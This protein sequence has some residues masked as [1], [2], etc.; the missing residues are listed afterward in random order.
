MGWQHA[1]R[2]DGVRA[3]RAVAQRVGVPGV[4]DNA[5]RAKVQTMVAGILAATSE[6]RTRKKVAKLV[7]SYEAT[8]KSPGVSAPAP[9]AAPEPSVRF[10][11]KSMLLTYN[12]DFFGKAFPDGTAAADD[13][14][15]L[16][17]LWRTWKAHKKQ[18]I[19]VV[20]STHTLEK[21]IH[22]TGLAD[23]FHI[24]WKVDF[25]TAV[26]WTTTES[27]SFHGVRPNVSVSTQGFAKAARGANAQTVSNRGHFYCW[28]PKIGTERVGSNW[29]PFEHYRV[30]G[31]WIDDL[32][33]EGKLAHKEYG[34]LSLRI[35]KGYASRKRDLEAV[36]ADEREAC[37][38]RTIVEVN[39]SLGKMKAPFRSFP[40]VT[41]W[42]DTFLYMAFRWKILALQADSD[43]GKSNF[44]E[45]LFQK[46]FCVT[47]ESAE[48]LD[49]KG[50]AADQFDGIVLDNVNSWGQLLRWRAVLQSRNAKSKGGRSATNMYSYVQ[51][52]YGVPIV[53]TVDFDAPDPE[54]LQPDH[55]KAS[56]W[57][58]RKRSPVPGW[59]AK[60]CS[61]TKKT[62]GSCGT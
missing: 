6:E 27:V 32:W 24:H 43:S 31:A 42:E 7:A 50:F 34:D 8:F 3:L 23:R 52:L 11:G 59:P 35:R 37:V 39:A 49:L 9:A 40:E 18:E 46:P 25:K 17:Q 19:E 13:V 28:A 58:L 20:R 47:V 26:D 22:A 60:A 14:R 57:L 29:R 45:S 41:A 21:S 5:S 54:L 38:D 53:A 30:L 44:A 55:P 51:Y 48:D 56:R 2:A 1:A 62:G 15:G 16:W 12:W 4:G 36:V 33:S 61:T 10:R